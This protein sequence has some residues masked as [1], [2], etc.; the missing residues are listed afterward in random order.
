MRMTGATLT[1]APGVRHVRM[2]GFSRP[3]KKH[4]YFQGVYSSP[5]EQSVAEAA[6]R[7]PR[8]RRSPPSTRLDNT[9]TPSA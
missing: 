5:A 6:T 3:S 9:A 4:L 8:R 1:S 2:A 7:R